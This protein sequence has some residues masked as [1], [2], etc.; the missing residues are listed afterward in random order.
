MTDCKSLS[1]SSHGLLNM[2]LSQWPEIYDFG[3]T[4]NFY[5]LACVSELFHSDHPRVYPAVTYQKTILRSSCHN[6]YIM[7]ETYF[8]FRRRPSLQLRPYCF[9]HVSAALTAAALLPKH[10]VPNACIHLGL[11][12]NTS[13]AR[14]GAVQVPSLYVPVEIPDNV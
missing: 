14:S 8:S 13:Y 11:L 9:L 2:N 7:L 6:M 5:I 3:T 10:N 12:Y 4:Q 1:V